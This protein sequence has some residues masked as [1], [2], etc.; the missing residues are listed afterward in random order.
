MTPL[1]RASFFGRSEI[2]RLL[3][4][5]VP[6]TINLNDRTKEGK[7]VFDL[8]ENVEVYTI[9]KKYEKSEKMLEDE[10]IKNGDYVKAFELHKSNIF[11]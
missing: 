5:C 11:N 9:L 3:L 1:L 4:N 6:C 10:Y 7:S 2:V 8:A